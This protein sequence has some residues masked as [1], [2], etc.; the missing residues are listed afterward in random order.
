[1]N[2]LP[3]SPSAERNKHA[4][5]EVMQRLLPA[6]GRMLEVA[7]GTGQHAAWLGSNLP[8]WEWHPTE[9]NSAA[10]PTIAARVRQSAATNIKPPCQLNAAEAHWPA[11]DETLASDFARPF[12]AVSCT[13]MLHIAPWTACLGLVAGAA[14]HLKPGGLLLIYG[15][16]FEDGIAAAQSNLDFDASLRAQDPQWGLRQ[17]SAVEAAAQK[18]GLALAERVPMPANNLM[19]VFRA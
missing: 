6:S 10:L 7:S 19:L 9:A 4:I 1:M 11:D 18:V 14:R 8:G 12:D 15:P 5:L 3:F 13:N 2:D 16:F 17:R